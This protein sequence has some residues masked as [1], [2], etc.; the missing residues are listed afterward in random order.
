MCMFCN[1]RLVTSYWFNSNSSSWCW[2]PIPLCLG[3][4]HTQSINNERTTKEQL[5]DALYLGVV[6][7]RT[8]KE[9]PSISI[10]CQAPWWTDWGKAEMKTAIEIYV[11]NRVRTVIECTLCGSTTYVKAGMDTKTS[12]AAIERP[13]THCRPRPPFVYEG[14]WKEFGLKKNP[15]IYGPMPRMRTSE[16]YRMEEARRMGYMAW[17]WKDEYADERKGVQPLYTN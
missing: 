3:E 14:W 4:P 11:D 6:C 13:C 5:K 10:Y 15:Y 17:V 7:Q 8:S 2:S 12:K 9:K 1:E 16:R